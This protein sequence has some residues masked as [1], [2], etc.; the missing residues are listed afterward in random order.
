[1]GSSDSLSFYFQLDQHYTFKARMPGKNIGM[2]SHNGLCRLGLD[3][4]AASSARIVAKLSLN[5]H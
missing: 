1:M 5:C 3:P 4:A 2:S